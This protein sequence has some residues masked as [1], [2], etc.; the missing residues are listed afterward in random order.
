MLTFFAHHASASEA[1]DYF[2][3]LFEEREDDYGAPYLLIQRQFEDEDD[4][5]CYVESHDLELVGHFD[6]LSARLDRR[7]LLLSVNQELVADV[8]FDVTEPEFRELER[9]LRIII[10]ELEVGQDTDPGASE[11]RR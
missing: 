5:S 4:E 3:V 7:R 9:I 8:V 6:V 1:G 11:A 10:P 2:Q